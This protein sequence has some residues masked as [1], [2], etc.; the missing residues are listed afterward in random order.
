MQPTKTLN[1]YDIDKIIN[2]SKCSYNHESWD[3]K[4]VKKILKNPNFYV[5]LEKYGFL[6]YQK[7]FDEI[8]I[9][10]I[11]VEKS[12][13]QN[14]VA[15]KMLNALCEKNINSKITLEVSKNNE[16]A[17]RLYG[18]FGF[19]CVREIKKY[20]KSGHSCLVLTRCTKNPNKIKL[21]TK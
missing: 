16:Y 12:M 6:L 9:I 7:I 2:L 11:V 3:E 13:R 5:V 4:F 14:G 20:Y 18:K 1:N 15:T 8:D 17:L 10:N 21:D 19:K